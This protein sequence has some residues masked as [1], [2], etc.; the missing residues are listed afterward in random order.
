M[1]VFAPELTNIVDADQRQKA[2]ASIIQ[3]ATEVF[4]IYGRQHNRKEK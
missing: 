1:R 3:S 2:A 4:W